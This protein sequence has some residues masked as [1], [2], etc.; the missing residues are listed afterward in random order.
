MSVQPRSCREDIN[1]NPLKW[2]QPSL[3]PSSLFIQRLNCYFSRFNT[4]DHMVAKFSWNVTMG[5][6]KLHV[7]GTVGRIEDAQ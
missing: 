6:F 3:R 4:N 5:K 2:C 7:R 1:M